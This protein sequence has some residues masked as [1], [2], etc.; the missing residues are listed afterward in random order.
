ME[1]EPHCHALLAGVVVTALEPVYWCVVEVEV[2][3]GCPLWCGGLVLNGLELQRLANSNRV[4]NVRPCL[5]DPFL[6]GYINPCVVRVVLPVT[7]GASL[8]DAELGRDAPYL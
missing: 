5:L 6:P 7:A 3:L 2:H 4:S 1:Q 8:R